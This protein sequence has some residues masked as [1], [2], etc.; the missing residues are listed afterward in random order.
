M[1][2]MINNKTSCFI[3][4]EAGVNHNGSLILAK[5]LIDIA[6]NAGAD[7]IKFQTF[8]ARDL[9]ISSAEMA[10][11]QRKNIGKSKSQFE[12]LKKLEISQKDFIQ[13]KKYCDKKRIIFLSTPHTENSV[14]F[15][16]SLVPFYKVSSSD[17]TNIPLLH[18]IA[19]K[20]KMIILSTGM[21]DIKEIREAISAIKSEK[22]NNITLLHCTTSYPC[23]EN[24]VNLNAMLSLKKEFKLP[25][26]YSDHTTG[27]IVPIMAATLGAEIIEKHFTLDKKLPGPDHKA[28]LEPKELEEMISMVRMVKDILGNRVKKPTAEEQ[29]IKKIARK[30]IVARV[31][32]PKGFLIREEMLAIKRPGNGISPVYFNKIIG[33][34][35]KNDLKEDTLIKFTDLK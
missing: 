27:I 8:T 26:G 2:K 19:K 20:K 18:K 13:L 34:K 21:S 6:K 24:K 3:I 9:V 15:L 16:D 33:K 32:I 4:A 30:S 7:A 29:K 31:N 11:Y 28:S 12:M 25:I 35:A 22:N 5:K 23:P 10:D 1:K 17:L 14:D